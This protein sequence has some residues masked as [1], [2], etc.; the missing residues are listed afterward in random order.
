VASPAVTRTLGTQVQEED[1]GRIQFRVR[2]GVTGHRMILDGAAV[3]AK[4]DEWLRAVRQAFP[5][6]A[7]T[8]VIS[9]S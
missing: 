3:T 1:E 6:T 4:I 7:E 8:R 9:A 2:L 5:P